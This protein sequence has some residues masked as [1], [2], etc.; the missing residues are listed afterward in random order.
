[1]TENS[2]PVRLPPGEWAKLGV[3]LLVP[4]VGV[5]L[6]VGRVDARVAEHDKAIVAQKTD[7][8]HTNGLLLRLIEQ[9]A[10]LRGELRGNTGDAP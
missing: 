2:Q 7:S 9:T 8:D 1:M 4:A 5:L 10:E 3:M 6:W